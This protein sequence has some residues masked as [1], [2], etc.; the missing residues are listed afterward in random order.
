MSNLKISVI[1]PTHDPKYL[2]E[3]WASLRDQTYDGDWEWC[4]YVNGGATFDDVRAKAGSDPRIRLLSHNGERSRCIGTIKRNAFMRGHGDVLLEMDHDDLLGPCAL[5]RTAEAFANDPDVGFVYSDTADW[6]PAGSLV[7]YHHPERRKAWESNGWKFYEAVVRGQTYLAHRAWEPSAQALS[8]IFWSPNHFRAWRKSVYVQ[9]GGH[10]DLPIADDH[11]L[12]IRTYLATRMRHIPECHYLY[13]VE[14]NTW[15]SRT[16]EIKRLTYELRNKHLHQLV[17]RECQLAGLPMLDLGGRFGCPEGWTSVDRKDADVICDLN[18]TW[19]FERNSIGAVRAFDFLEHLPDQIHTMRAIHDVL[20]PGG[21]I[22]SR[23]PSTDGRGA[24][25]DPTHVSFWNQNSFWYWTRQQQA[26]YIDNADVRFVAA[27]HFTSKP[28]DWHAANDIPM[29]TFDG[30]ALKGDCS[31][32][33]G[34]RL[35]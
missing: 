25:Q 3:T 15:S 26:R 4:I 24:W 1:T 21:W 18:K 31:H 10:S 28:T 5:E 22:L 29:V 12:L 2:D 35:I 17:E 13:R 23:T 14:T 8:L 34:E 20:R 27:R 30:W 33:P 6:S 16:D 19:P 9:I 11:E 32:L 7:T